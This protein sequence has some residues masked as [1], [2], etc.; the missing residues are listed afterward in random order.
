MPWGQNN[1]LQQQS[2]STS[3]QWYVWLTGDVIMMETL[4]MF[5]PG[6]LW[7]DK[8]WKRASYM[9]IGITISNRLDC[10]AECRLESVKG[11]RNM[12]R[13][14]MQSAFT[15]PSL[16]RHPSARR[17]NCCRPQHI[18]ETPQLPPQIVD[19]LHGLCPVKKYSVYRPDCFAKSI[20]QYV[21]LTK[22][23]GQVGEKWLP[24]KQH[25]ILSC[26]CPAGL[27]VW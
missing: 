9:S 23:R 15:I 1:L 27:K 26:S 5:Q 13:Y 20:A 14:I 16:D 10:N 2:L 7:P 25:N 21:S 8:Q 17:L 24:I 6:G 12:P 22:K 18:R 3:Q 4:Q 19:V 11:T